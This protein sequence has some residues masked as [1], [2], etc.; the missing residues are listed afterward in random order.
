MVKQ[1]SLGC[2]LPTTVPAELLC[3]ATVVDGLATGQIYV[4]YNHHLIHMPCFMAQCHLNDKRFLKPLLAYGE[5]PELA[6]V[7][8]DTTEASV[9][10]CAENI[11]LQV[12]YPYLEEMLSSDCRNSYVA[13]KQAVHRL[14]YHG[15]RAVKNIPTSSI[16]IV[17]DNYQAMIKVGSEFFKPEYDETHPEWKSFVWSGCNL[18][19]KTG[20]PQV[21]TSVEARLVPT[22]VA[23]LSKDRSFDFAQDVFLHTD[24][25]APSAGYE[26][27]VYHPNTLDIPLGGLTLRHAFGKGEKLIA[28]VHYEYPSSALSA[29]INKTNDT[30]KSIKDS[31]H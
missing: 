31:T 4:E 10:A 16:F 19:G 13:V 30:I 24:I 1:N 22:M 18:L 9:Y 29:A 15:V 3:Q 20:L 2:I 28:N 25:K 26:A 12:A 21:R 23:K 8:F 7:W 27:R 6:Q 14:E 17:T 5:W 11:C